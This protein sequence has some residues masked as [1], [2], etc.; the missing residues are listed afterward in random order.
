MRKKQ[1][2][3][4]LLWLPLVLS[5]FIVPFAAAVATSFFL[6]NGHGVR[7]RAASG[8]ITVSNYNV[9]KNLTANNH[10][11]VTEAL[12]PQTAQRDF[13]LVSENCSQS[14]CRQFQSPG[15]CP[16]CEVCASKG[17]NPFAFLPVAAQYVLM[18]FLICMSAM[19][20]GLTLGVMGLDKTGLEIVMHSDDATSAEYARKIYPLRATG[21]LLLCTLLLGNT[22]AN[23][24]FSILIAD[25][26]GG[27]IGFITSTFL[28]LIFA[29]IVPQSICTRYALYIGSRAVPLVRVIMVIMYPIAKPIAFCL[30]CALGEEIATTYSGSEL[31]KF[32]QIHVEQN[33]IDR[34]TANTMGGA[35]KYKDVAVREVMTPLANVFMLKADEV[36]NFETIAKIFKTGYSR[37]PVFEVSQVRNTGF[38]NIRESV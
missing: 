21:N 26:T 5:S 2:V 23:A 20:A 3:A 14:C 9:R 32:L 4:L 33:I 19:F 11:A 30:D 17:T 37:I 31:L 24:L 12:A 34:D 22:S 8:N 10:T 6:K 7:A 29:E 15:Q 25:K 38:G 16:V 35:L 1:S 28:I 27:I 13:L 36:L 18:I